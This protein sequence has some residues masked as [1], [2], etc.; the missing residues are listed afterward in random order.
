METTPK[1]SNWAFWLAALSVILLSTNVLLL[2][3]VS[4]LKKALGQCSFLTR[5]V[6]GEHVGRITGTDSDQ[7]PLTLR[8]E[9][10]EPTLLLLFSP[11]C[12]VCALNWPNWSKVISRAR[13]NQI[14]IVLLNI[15]KDQ[16][17]KDYLYKNGVADL[18][19]FA[20]VDPRDLVRN[21]FLYTP[22]TILLSDGGDIRRAWIGR[23]HGEDIDEIVRMISPGVSD[24]AQSYR[25]AAR[26]DHRC[27][28][29]S[30]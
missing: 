22:E 18:P 17:S 8:F 6:P 4:Y 5:P 9:N 12:S 25:P 24:G 20:E 19:F 15:S 16:V 28:T 27:R 1:T 13:K 3:E 29:C 11:K 21:Y 30:D 10:G 26:L 14:R 2:K 23:L 7:K